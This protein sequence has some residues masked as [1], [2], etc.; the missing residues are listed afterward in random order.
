MATKYQPKITRAR[1]VV[2]PY[3]PQQM[4]QIGQSL[5]GFNFARWDRGI[6][7]TDSAAKPLAAKYARRKSYTGRRR[8]V[9]DLNLTGRLR[10]S[11][12]VLNASEN[13]VTIGPV[14]GTYSESTKYGVLTNSD[15]LSLNQ[16]RSRMWAVSPNDRAAVLQLLMG[17]HKP[18]TAQNMRAA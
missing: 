11:I 9:R 2:S 7:A 15:V 12:R 13:K 14:D 8:A 3:T 17:I 6:D 4:V 16:R 10:D 18:V 5:I 1:F